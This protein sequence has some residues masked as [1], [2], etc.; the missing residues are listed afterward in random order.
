MT[1]KDP[2]PAWGEDDLTKFFDSA[3][4]NSWATFANFRSEYGRLSG[5]DQAL[6][7]LI[8][9]LNFTGEW[10]VGFFLLRVHS[11]FRAATSLA[12][13][14]QV[15]EAYVLLRSCLENALYGFYI[16][17]NPSAQAI[18][19]G[20]HDSEKAKK[21]VRT[22]FTIRNLINTFATSDARG[23]KVVE[24]LYERTIDMGAHPNE[25]GMMQSLK[26]SKEEKYVHFGI[27]YLHG[28][29]PSLRLCLKTT[30]QVGV[31]VLDIFQ[32]IFKERFD[33]LGLTEELSQ[34]KTGL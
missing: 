25:M 18:W 5:V 16:F 20:R 13:S 23:A 7:K 4:R 11:T 21:K 10:F 15:P 32:R 24:T 34:L 9:N 14:G 22:E 1:T 19:L 2:P 12:M 33:I 28:D 26:M 6:H 30:A 17:R 31:C 29:T 8:G 3:L 27:T